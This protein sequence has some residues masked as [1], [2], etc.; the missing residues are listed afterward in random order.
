M[1]T[2]A[3]HF[4]TITQLIPGGAGSVILN[5]DVP[6]IPVLTRN[7]RRDQWGGGA[8]QFVVDRIRVHLKALFPDPERCAW[9]THLTHEGFYSMTFQVVS[10]ALSRKPFANHSGV[11]WPIGRLYNDGPYIRLEVLSVS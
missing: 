10:Y 3:E 11:R 1:L 2:I 5:K 4:L 8:N 7:E 9:G 6:F